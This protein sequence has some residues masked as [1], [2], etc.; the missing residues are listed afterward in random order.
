VAHWP[1]ECHGV[2]R[3]DRGAARGRE[4]QPGANPR[5]HDGARHDH[6]LHDE[7]TTDDHNGT[8]HDDYYN[9]AAHDDYHG[10]DHEHLDT[11][12]EPEEQPQVPTAS[13]SGI[14]ARTPTRGPSRALPAPGRR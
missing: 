10:T 3:G 1:R 4:R 14:A 5:D 13:S 8:E 7:R 6:A 9:D 11:D 12:L 2:G